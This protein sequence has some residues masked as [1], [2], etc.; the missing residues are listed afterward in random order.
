MRNT[1]LLSVLILCLISCQEKT[2]KCDFDKEFEINGKTYAIDTILVS[3][4]NIE[5]KYFEESEIV[6]PEVFLNDSLNQTLAF[7]KSS[8]AINDFMIEKS[9]DLTDAS[10]LASWKNSTAQIEHLKTLDLPYSFLTNDCY[11]NKPE[12]IQDLTAGLSLRAY[13]FDRNNQA[14]LSLF[15]FGN[16]NLG[17]KESVILLEFLQTGN[18]IC[19]S[20][21][22]KY[23]VGARMMMKII[24]KKNRAKVNSAQ[25]ISASVTFGLAEVEFSMKTLGITG[26]GTATLVNQGAMTENTYSNFLKSVS[27][28]IVDVYKAESSYFIDPQLIPE[29]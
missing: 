27:N 2:V 6:P 1:I 3:N 28:L 21:V 25:Q 29:N 15:G 16:V 24:S 14:S 11:E 23:G 17:R 19:E 5:A 13:K 18:H 4:N 8:S 9:N 10:Y 22:N 7:Y 20:K 26:P 12:T